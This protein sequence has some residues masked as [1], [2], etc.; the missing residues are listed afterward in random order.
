MSFFENTRKPE[1]TFFLCNECSGD[2]D[3]DDK[4][5]EKISGMTIYR[6]VQLNAVLEQAGFRDVQIHKNKR[7]CLC[8]TAQK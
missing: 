4:W 1:G 5:T 2:T 8:M 3:K 6:D 7:G